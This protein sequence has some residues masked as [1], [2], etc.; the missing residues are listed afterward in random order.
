MLAEA[1]PVLTP[2]AVELIADRLPAAVAE[3]LRQAADAVVENFAKPF[4]AAQGDP[5]VLFDITCARYHHERI[6]IV[7]L[8]LRGCDPQT[9]AAAMRE[10][11]DATTGLANEP[12]LSGVPRKRVERAI[13]LY[14]RAAYRIAEL[15]ATAPQHVRVPAN[16]TMRGTR[17]DF[18]LL[19][20]HHALVA[21]PRSPRVAFLCTK[22]EETA[23]DLLAAAELMTLDDRAL[24]ERQAAALKASFG[25]WRTR[26]WA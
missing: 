3:E 23:E 11:A 15:A 12:G 6:R 4:L 25:A 10:V 22:A 13:E 20:L 7:A 19:A 21:E 2:R 16:F 8:L 5:T 26:G 1:A 18:A 14:Q 24:Q 17:L 9:A